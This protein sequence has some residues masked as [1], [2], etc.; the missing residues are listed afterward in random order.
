M[1]DFSTVSFAEQ[2]TFFTQKLQVLE[3]DFKADPKSSHDKAFTIAG[4]TS[5]NLLNDIYGAVTQLMKQGITLDQFKKQFDAI[6]AAHGWTGWTGEGT[7]AGRAW[8]ANIIAETNLRTSY[9]SGRWE[10]QLATKDTRPYLQYRHSH[11]VMHPRPVHVS[12][13]EMILPIEHPWWAEHYP[14]N[15]YGCK[16]QALSLTERDL[17]LRGLSVTPD[18]KI[19]N[20][21]ADSTFG[22]HGS[23]TKPST[24]KLQLGI[25]IGLKLFNKKKPP[26]P[27]VNPQPKNPDNQDTQDNQGD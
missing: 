20:G 18:N 12:W 5:A 17:Q 23:R 1:T 24:K 16:C 21:E 22:R 2:I 6:V 10:Q 15:G 13:N 19:P 25:K 3:K 7:S 11:G 14:P 26:A 9:S 27:P 4:V 8:R